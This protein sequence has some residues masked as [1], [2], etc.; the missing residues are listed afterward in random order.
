M[1]AW[2]SKGGVPQVSS[3]PGQ[4]STVFPLKRDVTPSITTHRITVPPV[5][6]FARRR[7]APVFSDHSTR[8]RPVQNAPTQGQTPIAVSASVSFPAP[9]LREA[10]FPPSTSPASTPSR[11]HLIPVRRRLPSPMMHLQF[12]PH[13][14]RPH[15]PLLPGFSS[16]TMVEVSDLMSGSWSRRLVVPLPNPCSP[17]SAA[18]P[19][20]A[21]FET[22]SPSPR[23][24]APTPPARDSR[25]S[26]GRVASK[27][28]THKG[29]GNFDNGR[30]PH[31]SPILC[32]SP[33]TQ[34][35]Y[36][37]TSPPP[38]SGVS[39]PWPSLPHAGG[40]T[41]IDT[42]GVKSS[43]PIGKMFQPPQALDGND[44]SIVASS[45]PS[46]S[47]TLE[48]TRTLS[49]VTNSVDLSGRPHP[50]PFISSPAQDANKAT[51]PG[52][53]KSHDPSESPPSIPLASSGAN[54]T[55][56]RVSPSR[57]FSHCP[58]NLLT[59]PVPPPSSIEALALR[60]PASTEARDTS[61]RG[62]QPAPALVNHPST[63]SIVH[64]DAGGQ[65][66]PQLVITTTSP[67]L[68]HLPTPQ[69][70]NRHPSF[71]L[72]R[73]KTC[74]V[75][76]PH[77]RALNSTPCPTT[78]NPEN[79]KDVKTVA[80]ESGVVREKTHMGYAYWAYQVRMNTPRLFASA[81]GT[82]PEEISNKTND[83]DGGANT[84]TSTHSYQH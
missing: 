35:P 34:A 80:W 37:P 5:A 11:S 8:V 2:K 72:S 13:L 84:G 71:T 14:H 48:A 36:S 70:D 56:G 58:L 30:S 59:S 3:P 83:D 1:T 51:L 68:H 57:H 6:I 44:T 82:M 24:L 65:D 53:V 67:S 41:G 38:S 20:S 10:C 79:L 74:E 43:L 62:V 42:A 45:P 17:I 60:V 15:L 63:L 28:T 16:P 27:G 22:T 40:H 32:H 78:A 18:T 49:A 31:A 12:P 29:A 23:S 7:V 25:D 61:C 81:P 52:S 9:A 26:A 55:Q 54:P 21:I 75:A 47:S 50:A 46:S 66:S 77:V 76:K 64:S 4:A 19:V 33:L 39:S 73:S 69:D